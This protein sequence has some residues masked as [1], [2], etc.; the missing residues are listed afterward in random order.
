MQ[1]AMNLTTYT[2][3][4]L[5]TIPLLTCHAFLREQLQILA[6]HVT[7]FLLGWK[8]WSKRRPLFAVGA[9]AKEN[10]KLL[11]IFL[12]VHICIHQSHF[13]LTLLHELFSAP[14]RAQRDEVKV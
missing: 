11:T 8:R 6:R 10:L 7:V 4:I 3:H 13:F 1:F 2:R 9:V 5:L 14:H 12:H